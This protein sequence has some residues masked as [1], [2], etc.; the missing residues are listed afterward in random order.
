MMSR[1][2]QV[3]KIT[4]N[5]ENIVYN[6]HCVLCI[7]DLLQEYTPS[8]MTNIVFVVLGLY[9]LLMVSCCPY[10]VQMDNKAYSIKG[11]QG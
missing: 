7:V 11:L 1:T 10:I 2:K 5:I 4:E 8:G 9:M 3:P 6:F